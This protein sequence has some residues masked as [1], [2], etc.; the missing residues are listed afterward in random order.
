MFYTG[1]YGVS[2]PLMSKIFDTLN[3]TLSAFDIPGGIAWSIAFEPLPTAITKH[4]DFNGGNSLGTE[5]MD[6]NGFSMSFSTCFDECVLTTTVMLLSPLWSDASS[7]DLV[8]NTAQD[9]GKRIAAV[10][11]DEGLLHRFQYLNYADPSQ[12]PIGS[13]GYENVDFLRSTSKKYDPRS[14]FQK[15]VKGGFK[16]DL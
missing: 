11:R 13:Y 7:N 8:Q 5:P 16:L 9:L 6:G 3:S 10:A 14:V 1:T 4:G 12:D 15:Q 2:A